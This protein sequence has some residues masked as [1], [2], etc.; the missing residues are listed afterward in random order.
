MTSKLSETSKPSCELP[1]ITLVAK[2]SPASTPISLR[3]DTTT[4][5]DDVQRVPA[6]RETCGEN[7]TPREAAGIAKLSPLS[8]FFPFSSFPKSAAV[9]LA[10]DD[11][12]LVSTQLPAAK[13]S[14]PFAVP[15]LRPPVGSPA[16]S[17]AAV[18]C[19]CAGAHTL[20]GPTWG[21]RRDKAR[22]V[23]YVWRPSPPANP[24]APP[25]T[26]PPPCSV[27]QGPVPS[28]RPAQQEKAFLCRTSSSSKSEPA[29]Q[30]VELVSAE[31]ARCLGLFAWSKNPSDLPQLINVEIPERSGARGPWREGTSSAPPNAPRKKPA[32]TYPVIL[33]VEEVIDPTPLNT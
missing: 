27:G 7:H 11:V 28:Y 30:L 10:A 29:K 17:D 15:R 14:D 22:H 18:P 16:L 20:S 3:A 19:A 26:C 5:G 9:T 6:G 1:A 8:S 13:L 25:K 23:L 31:D 21:W 33:H 12:T 32:L 2:E 4:K 24:R